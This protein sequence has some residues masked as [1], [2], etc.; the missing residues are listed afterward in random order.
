MLND[1]N[2][3]QFDEQSKGFAEKIISSTS[4]M[5][6]LVQ[7]VLA[8]STIS[9][10]TDLIA[11]DT[12]VAVQKALEDLELKIAEK[13]AVIEV[14]TLPKVLGNEGYLTQLFYNLIANAIKFNNETP[15]V[16]IEGEMKGGKVMIS[17]TD[18]GIGMDIV[19]QGRIFEPFLR[20]HNQQQYT[21]SGIG[22]AIVK[23]I[24]DL[25]KGSITVD[26]EVDKGTTFYIELNAADSATER[27][28]YTATT[29]KKS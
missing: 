4:R 17:V 1:H 11:V 22:L 18:N 2:H 9:D 15:L 20:L 14:R 8:L 27:A 23:K 5:R 13:S 25:H 29:G 12:N 28:V 16:Q 24:V 26:S 7:D 10:E 21:G 6:K 19:N 3:E